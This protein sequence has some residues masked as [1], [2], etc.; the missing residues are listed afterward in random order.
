MAQ[1]L[2]RPTVET[3]VGPGSNPALA[4]N[5]F[6]T[7]FLRKLTQCIGAKFYFIEIEM[8]SLT[9]QFVFVFMKSR[10]YKYGDKT[11]LDIFVISQKVQN[12]QV[13]VIIT[14]KKEESKI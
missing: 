1:W 6:C 9:Y 11:N 2:K 5:L 7:F 12:I 10:K 8:L 13:L 3:L 14:K 4:K